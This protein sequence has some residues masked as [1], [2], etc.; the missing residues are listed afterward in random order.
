MY[1]SLFLMTKY[2]TLILV[3]VCLKLVLNRA[4]S[5]FF[6]FVCE[7]N[8][9]SSNNKPLKKQVQDIKTES[10]AISSNYMVFRFVVKITKVAS[11]LLLLT[12]F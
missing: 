3:C 7:K 1:F 6:V 12:V 8:D 5:L 11:S 9:K 2:S 10:P 4:D